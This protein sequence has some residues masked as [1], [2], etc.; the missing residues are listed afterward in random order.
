MC[1]VEI[2]RLK[3]SIRRKWIW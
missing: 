1:Y 3:R 2:T